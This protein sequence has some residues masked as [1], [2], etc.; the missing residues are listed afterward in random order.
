MTTEYR[1]I[2]PLDVLYLRG[3]KTFGGPGDHGEALMPPWPSI[4]AGALR[5]RMLVDEHESLDALKKKEPLTKL[6]DILGSLEEPGSFRV[7]FFSLAETT[8]GNAEPLF[9]LPADLFVREDESNPDKPAEPVQIAPADIDEDVKSSYPLPLLP[10]ARMAK[11]AK[12]M[13]GVWLTAA[14]MKNYLVG[15][16]VKANHSSNKP[17]HLKRTNELWKIQTRLG[18]ALEA[19]RRTAEKGQIYTVDT[20]AMKPKVGFIAG[21]DGANGVVPANGLLRFGGDGRAAAISTCEEET[22]K[23]FASISEEAIETI[24]RDGRFRIVLLTPGIFSGGCKLPGLREDNI[25]HGPE[26]VTAQLVMACVSR[27]E[28]VSGWDLAEWKPKPAVR[29]APAGVV[30]WLDNLRGDAA[31]LLRIVREGLWCCMENEIDRQRRA[32]GFNNAL[33]GVWPKENKL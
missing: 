13:G 27:A 14:G 3:N 20:I 8:N 9:P 18:I 10:V 17:N 5:S 24:D 16:S 30:Y 32:E 26:G 33:V 31:T 22:L 1:F 21:V 12:A 23:P 2:E 19:Q 4:G 6:R 7:S 28:I 29:A 25:W 11:Q 15:E